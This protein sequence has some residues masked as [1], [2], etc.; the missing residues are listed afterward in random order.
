MDMD[1]ITTA[2]LL[3]PGILSTERISEILK[4]VSLI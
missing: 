2:E 3:Q 1:V 4:Y